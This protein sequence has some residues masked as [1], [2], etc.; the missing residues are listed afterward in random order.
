MEMWSRQSLSVMLGIIYYLRASKRGR[1]IREP[2]CGRRMG[3]PEL[4]STY[5]SYDLS[6]LCNIVREMY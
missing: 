1:S 6:Y 4:E 5:S 2:S 3:V